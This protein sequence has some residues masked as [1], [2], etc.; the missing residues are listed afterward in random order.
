VARDGNIIIS[1][2]YSGME[3]ATLA[4]KCI[5][6]FGTSVLADKINNGDDT[7]A[8]LASQI[9]LH[10][11]KDFARLVAHKYNPENPDAVFAAFMKC[12][13]SDMQCHTPTQYAIK[14]Q[15]LADKS[16]E[17]GEV[18]TWG[19]FFKFFRTFAKPTGLGFPGG[20]APAT[21]VGYAKSGYKIDLTF[22][23]AT[24]LRQIWLNTYPE[25]EQYLLWVKNHCRDPQHKAVY[26]KVNGK[27]RL[28]QFYCYDTPR[29]MHRA[30]ADYCACANGAGLQAFAA[31]GAL[32]ALY[33]VQKMVWTLA[34]ND[35][36]VMYGCFPINF[37]HDEIIWECP[38]DTH[39]DLRI[40]IVD[41]IMVDA[42]EKITPNVKARTE[43]SAMRR[44]YKE[45]EAVFVNNKIVPW[46]PEVKETVQ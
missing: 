27:K 25:M 37:V 14:S 41:K 22:E 32:D 18:V 20:L 35:N 3:L 11:D 34:Q 5:E 46:E 40:Q 9:A 44:W 7:H 29:G 1:T 26:T 42:M 19:E 10:M 43:S 17:H 28:R 15:Y 31:E 39:V 38:D 4:Q 45:A 13:G 24:Q 6:L 33:E 2:D 30:R 36:H 12:K 23:V 8:Y 21:M 16:K